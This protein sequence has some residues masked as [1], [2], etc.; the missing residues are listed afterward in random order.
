MAARSTGARS[1]PSS[2]PWSFSM[3]I[4][5]FSPSVPAKANVTHNTPEV[6]AWRARMS[7]SKATLKITM[8]N[9]A[10]TSM[11]VKTSRE[12]SSAARSF[13]A[14][15]LRARRK[16]PVGDSRCSCFVVERAI[17]VCQRL[18][19]EGEQVALLQL[20]PRG[21]GHD[22]AARKHVE[23]IGQRLGAHHVV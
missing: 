9:S 23:A 15:A 22:V 5:R 17:S 2:E 19:V 4:E 14:T 3:L 1:R 8:T 21:G 20:I 18:L 11:A 12:R 10:K 13:Q 16:A 6:T 7:S